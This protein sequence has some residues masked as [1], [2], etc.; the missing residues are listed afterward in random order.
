MSGQWAV[1]GGQ[2]ACCCTYSG[3]AAPSPARRSCWRVAQ[4]ERCT[5]VTGKLERSVS[6]VNSARALEHLHH[7]SVAIHLEHLATAHSAITKADLHDLRKH[8]RLQHRKRS[9]RKI[10]NTLGVLQQ[11]IMRRRG[12]AS[13]S[14]QAQARVPS[15]QLCLLVA[16][17]T[18]T[19]SATTSGPLTPTMVRYSAARDAEWTGVGL[20]RPDHLGTAQ[21]RQLPGAERPARPPRTNMWLAYIVTRHCIYVGLERQ[22]RGELL[23]RGT[24]VCAL[25][26][27]ASISN[28]P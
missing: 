20:A 22:L 21:Q 10:V 17:R 5:H 2:H 14:Q 23:H 6:V 12:G 8:R 16:E 9:D 13:P 11:L 19:P 15:P 1:G 3:A 7:C 28:T 18:L 27:Q 4:L 24:H 25:S 26:G